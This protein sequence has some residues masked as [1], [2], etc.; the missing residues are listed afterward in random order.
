[1]ASVLATV[2]V[3][4]TSR[5]DSLPRSLNPTVLARAELVVIRV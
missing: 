5:D 3:E 1:M 2:R 4:Q